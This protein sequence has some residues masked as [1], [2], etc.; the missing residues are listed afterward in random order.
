MARIV[1]PLGLLALFCLAPGCTQQS[2]QGSAARKAELT[3]KAQHFDSA[4]YVLAEEPVGAIGVI[5]ARED[6]KNL[7]EIVLVG[8]IGGRQNPWIEG[9]AAFMMI[10]AAMDVVADGEESSESQVCL[11]DCC[12][13]LRTECTTL[14]KLVDEKGAVLPIDA[15]QLLQ[16]DENDMVVVKGKVRRD[17][18]GGFS[19]AAH[20][21]Y[22]RK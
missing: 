18:E 14:V 6:S 15:R 12:A 1:Y 4:K 16:A 5:E 13:A 20:G 22:V 2:A 3:R 8:R 9:R 19:V 10:D 21:V 11:D 17:D 7:D